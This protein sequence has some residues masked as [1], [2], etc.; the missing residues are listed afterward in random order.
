M[1]HIFSVKFTRIR[2][3]KFANFEV[4]E[5]ALGVKRAGVSKNYSLFFIRSVVLILLILAASGTI[6]WYNGTGSVFNYV[7]AIDSSVSMMADDYTPN[8]MDAAKGAALSFLDSLNAK[9]NIGV[10][11][12]TGL[13]YVKQKMT[14]NIGDVKSAINGIGIEGSGGTSLG[15]A[16]IT[17]TNLFENNNKA[18]VIILLTDGQNNV[19]VDPMEAVDYLNDK[20]VLVNT[21]GIGTI[22]GGE[23]SQGVVGVSKLD[24][25]TLKSIAEATN[26]EYFMAENP[27]KLEDAFKKI[28]RSR[29]ERLSVQLGPLFMLIAVTVLILEWGL[30]NTRFRMLP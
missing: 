24:D 30:M 20:G 1:V 14:D 8:R 10:I 21:I 23:I 3:L 25:K 28:A 26:G 4:L 29:R 7:I 9:A 2:A 5:K 16:M 6:Y 19:G 27:T 12:F 17:A 18:N 11:T 22:E 15:N 13:T